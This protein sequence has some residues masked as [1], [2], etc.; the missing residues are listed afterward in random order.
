M[1]TVGG[2]QAVGVGGFNKRTALLQH[3]ARH[4]AVPRVNALQVR[5]ASQCFEA[6]LTSKTRHLPS[7]QSKGGRPNSPKSR[8]FVGC[9]SMQYGRVVGNTRLEPDLGPN[10]GANLVIRVLG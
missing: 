5:L 10:S 4:V 8:H 1:S 3:A 2:V 7:R 6:M 9:Y